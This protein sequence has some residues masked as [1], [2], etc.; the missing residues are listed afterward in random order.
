MT[1][2]TKHLTLVACLIGAAAAGQ[3][4]DAPDLVGVW[5]FVGTGFPAS[6]RCGE[7]MLD[8]EL[9]VT[10]KI[11]ARAYRGRFDVQETTSKCSSVLA[12]QSGVT[13]RIK[14]DKVSIEYDGDGW[15]RDALV[16]NGAVMT[17]RRPNGVATTWTK[18]IATAADVRSLTP[19]E[20]SELDSLFRELEPEFAKELRRRLGRRIQVAIEKSGIA[21]DEVRLVRT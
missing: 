16:L 12:R 21:A 4:Q 7:V 8:G 19:E 3:A 18:Q 10:K 20:E 5:T 2:R 14:G 9:Q 6:P 13:L 17:G 11:T 1:T 15:E